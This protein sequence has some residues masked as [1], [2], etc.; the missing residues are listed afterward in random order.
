M[1]A[2]RINSKSSSPT[3]PVSPASDSCSPQG[4]AQHVWTGNQRTSEQSTAT[5]AKV[6]AERS[7]VLPLTLF[8]GLVD[9]SSSLSIKQTEKQKFTWVKIEPGSK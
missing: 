3:G 6:L 2:R 1:E 8:G 4:D 9:E 5:L 7:E